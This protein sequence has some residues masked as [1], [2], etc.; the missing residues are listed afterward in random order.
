MFQHLQ[1]A[2]IPVSSEKEKLLQDHQNLKL[3]L[4]QEHE[5]LSE[6][7]RA[8]QQEVDILLTLASKIKGYVFKLSVIRMMFVIP[9]KLILHIYFSL[10]K[11]NR[12]LDAKKGDRLLELQEKQ[13]LYE[14]QMKQCEVRK[15]EISLE[16]NRS[17]ES[18]RNQDQL[19][20]NIDDNLNYRKTKAEVDELAREIESLEDQILKIGGVSTYE[21]DLKKHLQEKERLLSEVIELDRFVCLLR[22]L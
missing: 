13:S 12:Y 22:P 20:R 18:L 7:K 9:I 4:E 3:K 5:Q 11:L 19:K 15:R 8:Y 21:V 6:T 17:K 14:S 2:L 16:L 1:E 10:R